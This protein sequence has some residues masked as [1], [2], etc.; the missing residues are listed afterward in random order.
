M[1]LIDSEKK[2]GLT[3]LAKTCIIKPK[4]MKGALNFLEK[5]NFVRERLDGRSLILEKVE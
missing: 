2:I 1:T 5:N 3:D 4:V